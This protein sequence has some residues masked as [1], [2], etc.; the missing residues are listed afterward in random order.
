MNYFKKIKYKILIIPFIKRSF[1]YYQNII[2]QNP[3]IFKKISLHKY[4]SNEFKKYQK[5][6]NNKNFTLSK[7]YLKLCLFDK[8]DNTPLDPLYILQDSWCAKKIFE[9][10]PKHHYDIGSSVE[11]VGIISQF[12]P[13]TMID[14]RP[15]DLELN[16]LYFKKGNILNLPFENNSLESIS[17]ICVI[18]HIGLGRYGDKLDPFGS[19]KAIK[20]IKRVLAP[21]GNLYIS[22]PIDNENKVYFNAHRAFTREYILKLFQSL[23]LI[24]EKYLYKNGN[25]LINNYDQSEG[26]GTGFFHFKK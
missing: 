17:S 2:K 8:T 12:V 1:L 3:G 4:F 23:K 22:L 16:N 9:N 13:T 7:E 26:F 24:E 10:R 6:N 20:E 5:I 25:K 14:I 11:M 21:E 15:I 18:E 19:E